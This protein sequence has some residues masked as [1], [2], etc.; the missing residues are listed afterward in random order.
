MDNIEYLFE[1][2]EK[3]TAKRTQ[4]PTLPSTNPLKPFAD[5]KAGLRYE[6]D[7]DK[8]QM[9]LEETSGE[10]QAAIRG[11][12]RT[13]QTLWDAAILNLRRA[14]VTRAVIRLARLAISVSRPE[15]SVFVSYFAHRDKV[16]VQIYPV[17]W[18]KDRFHLFTVDGYIP[19]MDRPHGLTVRQIYAT[20][21]LIRVL[22]RLR[23]L[24]L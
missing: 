18:D 2:L 9:N 12:G 22:N 7:T 11:S 1:K 4:A 23:R 24:G 6:T 10:P 8:P 13:L 5:L 17:G 3:G 20:M 15:F 16:K 19:S 14:L 21:T